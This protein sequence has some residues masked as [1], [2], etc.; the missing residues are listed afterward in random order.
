MI[1]I[2]TRIF[3]VPSDVSSNHDK[4]R[5]VDTESNHQSNNDY[6]NIAHSLRE[7]RLDSRSAASTAM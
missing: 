6:D 1:N 3:E 5:G 4:D 7:G 2:M